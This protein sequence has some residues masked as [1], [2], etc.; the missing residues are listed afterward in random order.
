MRAI[1]VLPGVANS[2]RLDDVPE[3]PLSDGTV[4]VRTVAL[5]VCGTDREIIS[6]GYGYAPPGQQHLVLGHESLGQVEAAPAES[7][8]APGDLV[9]GI[10]RRPDP[11]PCP[12]CAVGEWDMC[13]NGRYT[14]RGIKERD[15]YGVERFR[16]E[17]EF[18]VKIDP[19]LG[20]LGVLLEP[21]SI[22]AKA[23]DHTERIGRRAQVWEPKTLLVTGAGPVGL[24][25]ALM[26]IQRGL[27]VHVLDHNKAGPKVE[28]VRTLGATYHHDTSDV[29]QL[30][31]DVM[32][33][34]TGAPAVIRDCLGATAPAGILCLAGVTEP[35][36]E[37]DIDI[38][39]LN[40]TLVLENDVVFGSVNANRR[41]YQMAADALARADKGWLGRMITRRVPL[42]RW[43]EA[44]E[45]RP[46]DIKVIIDFMS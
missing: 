37:F 27:D 28:L 5:G 12:A 10:V 33:E 9:V 31:P 16:I 7:G 36:S 34:C 35:G 29:E 4:L 20:I 26:G 22:L 21:A 42:D 46:G 1:T 30:K 41:H 8:L 23:W 18:T 14:E 45:R 11:V 40:R 43:S 44:L 38:G 15:G 6:G 25:A 13:R 24:L 39:G 32:M 2:A 17:P 3:P 19:A